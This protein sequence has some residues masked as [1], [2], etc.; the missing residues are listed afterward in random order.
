M[1]GLIDIG[2]SKTYPLLSELA[3]T[4]VLAVTEQLDNAPLVGGKS[5][6]LQDLLVACF[7][8]ESCPIPSRDG[9]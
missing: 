7:Y 8:P 4:L 3:R 1:Q 5:G 2:S 6:Y 9:G